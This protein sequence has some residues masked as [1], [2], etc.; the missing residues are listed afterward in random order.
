[1]DT[2]KL[3][4]IM[5]N[6]NNYTDRPTIKYILENNLKLFPRSNLHI[7]NL[8]DIKREISRLKQARWC[9]SE[10]GYGVSAFIL[11]NLRIQEMEKLFKDDVSFHLSKLNIHPVFKKLD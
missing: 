9:L 7:L 2:S 11:P 10:R 6:F 4:I 8:S 5:F 1:M 3:D